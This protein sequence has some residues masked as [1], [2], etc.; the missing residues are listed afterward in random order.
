[1]TSESNMQ[2]STPAG[3]NNEEH[4]GQKA[5]I[6][7]EGDICSYYFWVVMIFLFCISFMNFIVNAVICQ[8]I[9]LIKF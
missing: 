9:C 8:V 7:E 6:A 1:M 5:G 4:G 2:W 3:D